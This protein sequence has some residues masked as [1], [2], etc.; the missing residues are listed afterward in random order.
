MGL[1]SSPIN[2]VPKK[3]VEKLVLA[4]SLYPELKTEKSQIFLNRFLHYSH[5]TATVISHYFCVLYFSQH[6]LLNKA[7]SNLASTCCNYHYKKKKKN[8]VFFSDTGEITQ[9]SVYIS[10]AHYQIKSSTWLCECEQR[11][12]LWRCEAKKLNLHKLALIQ[13]MK[14]V[15]LNGSV[16]V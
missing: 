6:V 12:G 2:M 14:P 1:D 10:A 15:G 7:E 5:A 4:A 8:L 3:M 16:V 9:D 11:R 13:L